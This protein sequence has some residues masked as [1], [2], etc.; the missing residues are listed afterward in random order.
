MESGRTPSPNLIV[1]VAVPAHLPDIESPGVPVELLQLR[2]TATAL[3]S[4]GGGL[5]MMLP[6]G[7]PFL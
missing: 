2:I 5:E 6:G 4:P 3:C 7:L 1:G